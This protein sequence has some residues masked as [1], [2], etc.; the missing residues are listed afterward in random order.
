MVRHT[1]DRQWCI[2]PDHLIEGTRADNTADALER[3]RYDSGPRKTHCHRD[4]PRTADNLYPNGQCKTC[5]KDKSKA[6]H[7]AK[8]AAR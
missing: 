5:A 1:C 8:M 3:G 6:R 2:N 7:R 4:H